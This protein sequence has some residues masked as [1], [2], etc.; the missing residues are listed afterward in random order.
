MRTKKSIAQLLACAI[1]ALAV[2]A[3]NAEQIGGSGTVIY[4]IT[5]G[6]QIALP[7]DRMLMESHLKGVILADDTSS[8][9]HLSLQDCGS[10]A[11]G[12]GAGMPG[13][14]SGVCV[15]ADKDGDVWWLWYNN[16][17][18]ERRWSVISGTGKYEGMT[19]SGTTEVLSYMPD[20][21]LAITWSG[22]INM[23]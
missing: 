23:K 14:D 21:R 6:A 7:G 16:K 12:D 10:A 5:P 17:G 3:G 20:G 15:A 11:V 18:D 9:L 13:E 19:G 22:T 4:T 1:V 2:Q 8:P